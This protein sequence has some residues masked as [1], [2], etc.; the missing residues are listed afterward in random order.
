[1]ISICEVVKEAFAIGCL[2]IEAEE[3]LR[4]LLKTKYDSRDFRAFMLLQHAVASGSIRQQSRDLVA[5]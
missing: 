5:S 1:M 2:T 3:Q 4:Q